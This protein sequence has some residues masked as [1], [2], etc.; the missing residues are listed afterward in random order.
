MTLEE[1]LA[2][3]QRNAR[4]YDELPPPGGQLMKDPAGPYPGMMELQDISLR[5]NEKNEKK[6]GK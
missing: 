2:M 4:R 1:I 5:K 6:E 3:I